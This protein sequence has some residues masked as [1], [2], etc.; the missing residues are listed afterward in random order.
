[1]QHPLD[2]PVVI[3]AGP[4]GS[5]VV[6]ALTGL[7]AQPVVVTRT[8]GGAHHIGGNVTHRVGDVSTSE[9]AVAA[10]GQATAVFQCS[11]PPYHRWTEQFRSQQDAILA[12]CERRSAVLVAVENVY[13]YGPVDHVMTETTPLGRAG[14]PGATRKGVVRAEAWRDLERAHRAGRVAC[15]AVRASDFVGPGVCQSVIGERFLR[16]ILVGRPAEVLGPLGV[17][18]SLTAPA[19]VGRAMV[20]VAE[21]D[22]ARGRAWHAPTAPARTI[23]EVLELATTAARSHGASGTGRTRRLRPSLLRFAGLFDRSA[24]EL[25]EM[26]YQ[27]DRDFIVDSTETERRFGLEPIP[28]ERS[29]D[30]A[31]AWFAGRSS[32]VT[33]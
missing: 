12:A 13:G 33:R 19:D 24:G 18:H 21:H 2:R 28:L 3:G 14:S 8:P 25:V 23:A 20:A 5:A 1:M 22:D 17:R 9:G 11:Q 10:I 29:I 4:V 15:G 26:L 30:D 16:P 32:L 31:V 27:F 6:E 7:G